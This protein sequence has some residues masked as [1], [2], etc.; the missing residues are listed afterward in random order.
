MVSHRGCNVNHVVISPGPVHGTTQAPPSKS[1]THRALLLGAQAPNGCVVRHPLLSADTIATLRGLEIL[2]AR[3]QIDADA[4]RFSPAELRPASQVVDCAN[5]GTTLRLLAATAARLP[6]P[7]TMTGDASLRRRPNDS[8][9]AALTALGVQCRSSGGRAPLSIQGPLRPGIAH[10]S[11]AA[12]SQATSALLLALPFAPGDSQVVVVPPLQSRPYIDVTLDVARQAG[13]RLQSAAG[14]SLRIHVPGYQTV[15]ATHLAVEGDWSSAAFPLAAA[16]VTGGTVTVTGLQ[17][18]SHQGDRRIVEWLAAFGASVRTSETTVTCTGGKLS[19]PGLV[20][21][22]DTPDLFPI[23]AVIAAASRGTTELTGAAHLR[24]KESDRIAVMAD[25]LSRMGIQVTARPDGLRVVGGAIQGAQIAT[26]ADHRIHMS[27]AVAA[28]AAAGPSWIDM[29]AAA[30][31]SYPGFHDAMS[32]LGARI[33][34]NV[35]VIA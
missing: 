16:A 22:G 9:L 18:A 32:R 27:F 5:S 8:L 11:G 2:G 13:L 17:H 23:I 10:V 33:E 14:E 15:T 28:L 21:V 24:T 19:S 35:E 29:P 7:T 30:A 3:P 1:V 12:G 20:D 4:I 31:V 26:A 34:S 25:G 6:A